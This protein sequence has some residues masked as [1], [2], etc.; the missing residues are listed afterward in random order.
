MRW[1]SIRTPP[2]RLFACRIPRGASERSVVRLSAKT[3][4]GR[5]EEST[6][7]LS[8]T[9][10]GDKA[11]HLCASLNRSAPEISMS[12]DSLHISLTNT[13][14]C[15]ECPEQLRTS[16]LRV[17]VN[18]ESCGDVLGSTVNGTRAT[19]VESICVLKHV[20]KQADF[21]LP[22]VCDSIL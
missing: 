16:V 11:I 5:F 13:F 1:S 3:T 12:S 17:A 2:K 20:M 22:A 9:N 21:K 8:T 10:L 15:P 7:W 6:L 18:R 19:P 14:V 4:V